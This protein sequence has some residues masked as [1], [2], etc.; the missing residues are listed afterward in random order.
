M[1]KCGT[2]SENKKKLFAHNFSL[3]SAKNNYLSDYEDNY[4]ERHMDKLM[5]EEERLGK[6]MNE[7]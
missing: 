6:I 5:T 3:G 7:K 2:V 4:R 1:S